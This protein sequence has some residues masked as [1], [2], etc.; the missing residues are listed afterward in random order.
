MCIAIVKIKELTKETLHYMKDRETI[1]N[2]IRLL[3]ELN[4]LHQVRAYVVYR[5]FYCMA[6][7]S[8]PLSAVFILLALLYHTPVRLS[9]IH[10]Y[11]PALI[12]MLLLLSPHGWVMPPLLGTSAWAMFSK[13]PVYPPRVP[14]IGNT[15]LP[16]IKDLHFI[17]SW[18]AVISSNSDDSMWEADLRREWG[19]ISVVDMAAFRKARSTGL[20]F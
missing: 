17:C 9:V 8:V 16:G 12:S 7:G 13:D 5:T 6:C 2:M 11:P 14:A 1:Q 10:F 4:A 15:A 18:P 3:K 19:A 20:D